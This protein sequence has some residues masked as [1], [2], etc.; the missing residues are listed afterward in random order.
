MD[1]R[2][3]GP[4]QADINRAVNGSRRLHRLGRLH[5]IGGANNGKGGQGAN[6]GQIL[7]AVGRHPILAGHNA[8]VGADQLEVEGGLGDQNAQL[9]KGAADAKDAESADKGQLA[10]GGQAGADGHHIL[11][12]GAEVKE[13]LGVLIPP[14]VGKGGHI[15]VAAQDDQVGMGRGHGEQGFAVGLPEGCQGSLRRH[16][17]NSFIACSNSCALG[18]R[19][20]KAGLSSIKLTPLPLT[21]WA[22]MTAGCSLGWPA[23]SRAV[24]RAPKSWPSI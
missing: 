12:G 6:Q 3:G 21:V 22:M 23:V 16:Q 13:A 20:W 17:A 11:L 4:G 2:H 24:S 14:E 1:D 8:G 7:D 19:L 5:R 15:Q 10:A 18:V 9:V